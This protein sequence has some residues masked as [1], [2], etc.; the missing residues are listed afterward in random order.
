MRLKSAN[1][2]VLL[3]AAAVAAAAVVF[4][5]ELIHHGQARNS[6]QLLRNSGLP[7]SVSTRLANLMALSPL[8]AKQAPDFSLTDQNG[9]LLSLSSLRGKV[10][11]LEFMDP[12]CVDICPIVS[13]EFIHAYHDLGPTARKVVFAA[14]NVNQYHPAVSAVAQFTREH[15]L[16]AIPDWHFFTGPVPRLRAV[17][18]AYNILVRPR[19]PSADVIHSSAIYFIDSQGRERYVSAPMADYTKSGAA[20][21][22]AGPLAEWGRGIALVA[23][24]LVR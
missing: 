8:P 1:R 7:P 5:A 13:D 2:G 24:N 3:V 12:H 4:S 23:S 14:I 16:S 11:V 18:R 15:Q 21:L 6:G 22:P 20:Y 10:V 19:G 17:W 9:H